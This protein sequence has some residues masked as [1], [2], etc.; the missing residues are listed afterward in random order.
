VT[1]E[2]NPGVDWPP[3]IYPLAA[4][5]LGYLLDKYLPWAL[6]LPGRLPA[7]V[8]L[9][10]A[11]F[12]VMGWAL[13]A[14]RRHQTTVLP[15]KANR[16]LITDGPFR[17]TRNPIYLAFL[18][19]QAAVALALANAWLLLLLPVTWACLRYRVIK[20]EEAYL[21]RRYGKVFTAYCARVRRWL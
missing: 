14:F 9:L 6:V 2:D 18:L 4:L 3:P 1:E 10:A 16:A 21:A 7:A 17:Y 19:L 11:A 20:L 8:F 5:G 12:L 13:W 15:H